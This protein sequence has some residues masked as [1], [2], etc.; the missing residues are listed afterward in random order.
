LDIVNRV[1]KRFDKMK[2]HRDS[3][4]PSFLR[5][6]NNGI[7]HIE[8][9]VDEVANSVNS[10]YTG[11]SWSDHWKHCYALYDMQTGINPLHS[12]L[13]DVTSPLV[14][15][16]VQAM[17]AQFQDANTTGSY[18]AMAG[19][20]ETV[21][22]TAEFWQSNWEKK[23]NAMDNINV[24]TF[25]ETTIAGTAIA[26]N[27]HV[28]KVRE[29]N[30][31]LTP[32]EV[33]IEF[34]RLEQG[35]EFFQ[36]NEKEIKEDPDSYIDEE[37]LAVIQEQIKK[38][39]HQF[40]TKK[41]MIVDFDDFYAEHVPLEQFYVDPS[42]LN[43][44][45]ITRD[46]R[47]CVWSY[48]M[49]Y[50]EL[51]YSYLNSEDPFVIQSNITPEIIGRGGAKNDEAAI[52]KEQQDLINHEVVIIKY[53]NKYTDEYIVIAN[54]TIIR[55]GPL[56]YNHKLLPFS[57][58]KCIPLKNSF[59][60]IGM[61]ALLDNIQT[62]D[63]LYNAV[64]DYITMFNANL[65]ATYDDEGGAMEERMT[66]IVEGN[67][68][69]KAGE[70]VKTPKGTTFNR[71]AP[72]ADNGEI[73]KRRAELDSTAVKISMVSPLLVGQ[74]RNNSLVRNNQMLAEYSLT[75]IRMIINNWAKLR[76]DMMFQAM[77]I[78]K[79][80]P[81]YSYEEAEK[82]TDSTQGASKE[83][84]KK[85]RTIQVE[86]YSIN[87]DDNNELD[88]KPID[89]N[90]EFDLTPDILDSFDKLK[91]HIKIETSA[92]ASKTLQAQELQ[93]TM[94]LVMNIMSNPVLKE[95]RLILEMLK[96]YLSKKNMD[97][98]IMGLLKDDDSEEST[99]LALYQNEKMKE[100]FDEPAIPGMSESHIML[101]AQLLIQTIM[102]RE[103]IMK[104]MM[105]PSYFEMPD[106]AVEQEF[107][108]LTDLIDI[109]QKHLSGD[110]MSRMDTS[111][112]ALTMAQGAAQPQQPQQMPVDNAEQALDDQMAGNEQDMDQLQP[113]MG[114]P[115]I[116]RMI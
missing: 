97:S 14:F 87:R 112:T 95:N 12:E 116:Q 60:G 2:Q 82:T 80:I 101:H 34:I 37:D 11:F 10:T 114:A 86:G 50:Q 45:D 109:M 41:E 17:L 8:S 32:Q 70:V 94:G 77:H 105:D 25:K 19:V 62:R 38:N 71:M 63:E 54:D 21:A 67:S 7:T 1:T 113:M 111:V 56:P 115:D 72:I 29:V 16:T 57:V 75:G 48:S 6:I 84:L 53:F 89:G 88:I 52:N 92:L 4:C 104:T 102:E 20:S 3:S 93:D 35:D 61:G 79:Q 44:N 108:R 18:T 42:A 74:M 22:R 99:L 106:P 36:E 90:S 78:M 9:G 15:S 58:G 30:K 5:P 73:A 49:P 24:P 66:Q 68:I 81:V 23:V 51:I 39:P 13:G 47:D 98:K 46:A 83:A 64:Q 55:K 40:L 65:P 103:A 27:S 91:V 26:Y 43:L 69:I 96:Q 107:Q 110:Q 85:Y 100:G 59:Y 31:M 28:K 76:E 33:L